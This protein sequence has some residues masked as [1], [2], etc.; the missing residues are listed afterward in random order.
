MWGGASH[1][2]AGDGAGSVK[3]RV[4]G[5]G[6]SSPSVTLFKQQCQK[7]SQITLTSYFLVSDPVKSLMVFA[8]FS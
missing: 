1:R 5:E 6:G 4:E 3:H 8:S 2:E 7:L